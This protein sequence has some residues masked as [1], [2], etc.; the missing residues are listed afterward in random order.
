MGT[1]HWVWV[2]AAIV[3]LSVCSGSVQ[4]NA[5]RL[6]VAGERLEFVAQVE[7]GYVVKLGQDAGGIRA[8]AGM[9]ALDAEDAA[10]IGGLDR[11][12]VWVVA[13][14]GPA[15]R[16]EEAIRS[17]RA[18]GHAA[19]AAPLFSSNGET[20]AIIPEIV[21]R[22]K[23]G[24][25]M[26]EV[27]R[28]SKAAGCTIIKR[29]EFT[30][31]EYLLEVLGPDADSVFAA[32]EQLGQAPEVEWA[33]PNTAMRPKLPTPVLPA[34]RGALPATSPAAG[35]VRI[36]SAGEEAERT[37]VFPNDEYFPMQWH[38]YNTG[39]SGGTPGADIRA[40]E[41][42]EITTGDPNI[43]VAVLDSGVDTSHPDLV[44]NLT[45]GYDF[46]DGDDKPYPLPGHWFNSHGTASAGLAAAEGDNRIGVC[47]VTW[48]CAIMP[49]RIFSVPSD[50]LE[51]FTTQESIATA[52]RWAA[53]HGADI[54]SNSW[55]WGSAPTPVFLSGIVDITTS[56]GIGRQGRGCVVLFC[57]GNEAGGL[58]YPV[59][60]PEVVA[61]GATDH[62][63][64]QSWYSNF[65][66]ELD[67]VV[68]GGGG[69]HVSERE[70]FLR[71]SNDMLWTT[72]LTGPQGMS[73]FNNHTGILDYTEKM[74]C[75]SGACPIAA[76]V[77][78]LI[79]SIEPNLTSRD[80]QD[81]MTRSAK[82]LGDPGKDDYYGWGRVDARAAL[83]MVLTKRCDLNSDWSVDD[84]DLAIVEAALGTNDRSA[85]VAPARR[86]GVVDGNDLELVT[87]YL[88]TVIPLGLIAH[89]TLDETVGIIA[90]DS[91][92]EHHDATVFG[93][94]LWQPEGGKVGGAL[95]LS[96]V[97]NF[98]ITKFSCDPAAGPVTVFAWVKGGGPGQ[99]VISQQGGVNWLM[100]DGATGTLMTGLSKT[101]RTGSELASEAVI[102]DGDWHRVGFTW[103]GRIRALYVD[104]VEVAQDT[105]DSM[106]G[107][108]GNVT[109]GAGSSTA[110]TTFWKGLIDDVRIY[111]RAVKP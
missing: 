28:L 100:A 108:T 73:V 70:E 53:A 18:G 111:D 5:Y 64:H 44:R 63:D 21:V 2:V 102:T 16:N 88:G 95:Q 106:A 66:S 22:M 69:A 77:A 17:L 92:G 91:A 43:V 81:F 7:R 37:G 26:E 86:D 49:I 104:G 68:P 30:Q 61:V 94:P 93:A 89:W 11:R 105:Q 74:G 40:P 23:P 29:M 72:D 46:V 14:E 58:P 82:D 109:I 20:V 83:D 80:V 34:D 54:L 48:N 84:R 27:E 35:T 39:Q 41:A 32:V 50:G 36:A 103:D 60:Y 45:V 71:L 4:A 56:G 6:T 9:S 15:R 31:Q 101:G 47:G 79:L 110:P 107:S 25:E 33:C 57:A 85:D 98:L 76:G 55:Y 3:G 8:L 99:V 51:K 1:R 12:G 10:P 38:L 59:K 97:P 75:T 19:Y 24:I 78:A 96:G 90:H 87:R 65:G 52:F 42:W 13:N 67:V 62:H